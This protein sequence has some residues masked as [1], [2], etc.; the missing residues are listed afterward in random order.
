[1]NTRLFIFAFVAALLPVSCEFREDELFDRASTLRNQDY[2]EHLREILMAPDSG[3]F[4]YNYN[5][6]FL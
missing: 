6:T 5:T 1:M 4:F 3:W 2:R